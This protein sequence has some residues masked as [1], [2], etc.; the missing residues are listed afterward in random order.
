MRKKIATLFLAIIMSVSMLSGCGGA[1]PEEVNAKIDEAYEN[2]VLSKELGDAMIGLIYDH[3]NEY[4]FECFFY[5]DLFEQKKRGS[6][7]AGSFFGDAKQTFEYR[8][9]IETLMNASKELLDIDKV[10]EECQDYYDAVKELYKKV[11]SYTTF[12]S[13]FP[14]GYSKITYGQTFSEHQKEY[15]ALVSEVEFVK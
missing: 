13:E 14:E 5:E 10:P 9:G 8:D 7:G 6:M 11:D 12:V 4:E 1:S 15:D 3:W 2:I